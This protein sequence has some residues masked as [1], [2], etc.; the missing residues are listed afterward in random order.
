METRALFETV[1]G[2]TESPTWNTWYAMRRRCR[3]SDDTSYP[4][5]GAR[6]IS[7]CARWDDFRNFLADMGERPPGCSIER[8]D[9]SGDYE[10]GNCRWA[11]PKEQANNRRARRLTKLTAAEVL[12]I[13]EDPRTHREIA[14]DYGISHPHVT[15]IKNRK[16]A[17]CVP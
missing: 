5:Y 14:A 8:I 10:P 6:G 4:R 13:R 11:T 16:V 15:R 2:Q 3:K 9:N 12:A 17:F 1:H 7:V